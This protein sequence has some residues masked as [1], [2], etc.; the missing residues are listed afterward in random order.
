MAETKSVYGF[1]S[2]VSPSLKQQDPKSFEF[3]TGRKVEVLI[4]DT[5]SGYDGESMV[6]Y[7]KEDSHFGL[8]CPKLK[9]FDQVMLLFTVHLESFM[10]GFKYIV[11]DDLYPVFNDSEM[12]MNDSFED[13]E[14][15]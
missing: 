12:N 11:I 1:I 4:A 15:L 3:F 10:S 5:S 7:I 6:M 9:K 2:M 13:F 14:N 8:M